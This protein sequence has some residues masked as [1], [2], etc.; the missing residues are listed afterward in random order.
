MM[1]EMLFVAG[2]GALGA[3]ARFLVANAV[4]SVWAPRFPFATLGI[5]AVGSLVMGVLYVLIA[6][7]EVLHP[8]WRSVAMVGFLGAFT[9]FSTFSLETVT[10][11]ESGRALDALAYVGGSVLLCVGGAWSG[12]WLARMAASA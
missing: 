1:R 9:T 2:G 8:D 12:I 4:L 7:R 10:L 6:E 3:V 11:L 5:N